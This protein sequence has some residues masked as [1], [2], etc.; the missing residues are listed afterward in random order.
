MDNQADNSASQLSRLNAK[1]ALTDAEAA[2]KRVAEYQLSRAEEIRTSLAEMKAT[3]VQVVLCHAPLG[4]DYV[5]TVMGWGTRSDVFSLRRAA[6]ILSGHYC[7]G[8]FRLPFLGPVY[9][10]DAGWF[11]GDEGVRGL[12]WVN[13]IP[14]YISPGL[15]A[16]HAVPWQPF[17]LFN[18][19]TVTRIT[20]T[21][22][23]S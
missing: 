17:R 22:R 7:G 4:A 6:L 8:Q 18:T 12:S 21:S 19:P 11:P 14:E 1:G 9:L 20:L 10:P 15:G 5:S 3:D 23:G 16:S 2:Q 13:G